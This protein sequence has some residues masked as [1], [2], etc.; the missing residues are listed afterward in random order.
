[1]IKY[2]CISEKSIIFAPYFEN[3]RDT[4]FFLTRCWLA[5][6]NKIWLFFKDLHFLFGHVRK[7]YYLCIE[8]ENRPIYREVFKY[9]MKVYWTEFVV[10]FRGRW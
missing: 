2:L 1:L 10:V 9:K 5:S 6:K 8:F 7:K 3:D 4:V